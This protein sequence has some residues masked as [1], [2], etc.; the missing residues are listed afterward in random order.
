MEY[1]I[2]H[3]ADVNTAR[4]GAGSA[5][6]MATAREMWDVVGFLL[7]RGANPRKVQPCTG[8]TAFAA[9][10]RSAGM[11]WKETPDVKSYLDFLC[12]GDA[13]CGASRDIPE[14]VQENSLVKILQRMRN[15]DT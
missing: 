14:G 7:R 6:S 10:A 2:E 1:F 11:Q 3:G 5:V 9:A 4:F 13:G 8:L 15:E 12:D